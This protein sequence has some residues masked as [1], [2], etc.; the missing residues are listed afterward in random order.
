MTPNK[1]SLA[2]K[3]R[4]LRQALRV[5]QKCGTCEECVFAATKALKETK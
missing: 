1:L 2:Q 4:A 5:V 3:L